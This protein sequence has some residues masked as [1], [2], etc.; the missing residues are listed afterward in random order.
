MRWCKKCEK[1]FS[2]ANF[3]PELKFYLISQKLIADF[4]GNALGIYQGFCIVSLFFSGDS[5][6]EFSFIFCV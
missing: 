6:L 3:N 1:N 2:N 5:L 4:F